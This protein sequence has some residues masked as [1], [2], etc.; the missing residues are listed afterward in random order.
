MQFKHLEGL[1]PAAV[2]E[3]FRHPEHNDDPWFWQ[4]WMKRHWHHHHHHHHH[5]PYGA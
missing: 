4:W 1:D 3:F 2:D 5:P